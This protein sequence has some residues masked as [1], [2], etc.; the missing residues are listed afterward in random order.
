M[1]KIFNLIFI[2]IITSTLFA[3]SYAINS[4]KYT[5]DGATRLNNLKY[6]MDIDEELTFET[7]EALDIYIAELKQKIQNNR[8]FLHGDVLTS[9][10]EVDS[11][12]ISK[13][14][15]E[16]VIKDSWNIVVLPYPQY[17]SNTGL[18]LGFR[19]KDYNFL[20]S[21]QTLSIRFDYVKLDE[22]GTEYYIDTD[23]SI[24]FYTENVAWAIN[25]SEDLVLYPDSP[26]SN[27]TTLGLSA[28]FLLLGV[29][30]YSSL[31]QTFYTHKDGED[32]PDNYYFNTS[33]KTGPNLTFSDITFSPRVVLSLPYKPGDELS[34][35][36]QGSTIG[37]S[38]TMD[39]GEIDLV[40]NFKNGYEVSLEQ[41]VN[42]N[43]ESEDKS[44]YNKLELQY[45]KNFSYVG[46]SSRFI[47]LYSSDD[48]E[49]LGE[50]TRGITNDR[51]TSTSGL[52]MN[53]DLPI[54]F[55]LGPLSR[56]F[57]A[58]ASPFMDF[59]YSIEDGSN[60][61]FWYG[62]GLEGFAYLTASRSVYMRLSLGVDLEETF[63]GKN[64]FTDKS[65]DGERL[66]ELK[67][68]VGHH[69]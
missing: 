21:M 25:V 23:F 29:D 58:Q 36:R 16:V 39:Y 5:I 3:E 4:V 38:H 13:V 20:G 32:D 46:I 31:S 69:Y 15:I 40:E 30:W 55:P 43:F 41:S 66:W 35:D 17:D 67:I 22:G 27:A 1:R 65:D 33:A 60:N 44:F 14:D 52:V 19:A 37:L 24:P 45:H 34:N 28:D 64:F 11:N 6:F 49:A 8:V 26:V 10:S 57:E 54:T 48:D 59:A 12:G 62:G 68:V 9:I 42:H 51:I 63:K 7:K 56:W 53:L 47:A 50:E 61:E 2:L 18:S